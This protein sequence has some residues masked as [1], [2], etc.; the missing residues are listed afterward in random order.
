MVLIR[1][2]KFLGCLALGTGVWILG[3]LSLTLGV[4]GAIIGWLEIFSLGMSVSTFSFSGLIIYKARHPLPLEDKIFLFFRTIVLSMLVL[5]SS[6]GI[7]VGSNRS[8]GFAFIYSKAVAIHYVLLILT[9]ALSLISTFLPARSDIVEQCINESTSR[10]TIEF[11]TPGWSLVQGASISIVC[12]TL[13]TQLYA[14]IIARN[15]ADRLD[16]ETAMIFP[17][18]L[19]LSTI[20][21]HGMGEEV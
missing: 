7:I 17:E 4:G 2:R 11:C 14:F 19:N 20:K 18:M 3:L 16:L 1:C 6:V 21:L 8:I 15:Y 5:I 10:L 12:A 13:L 9:L